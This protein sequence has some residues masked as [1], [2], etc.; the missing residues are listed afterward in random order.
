MKRAEDGPVPPKCRLTCIGTHGVVSHKVEP[1]KFSY[2][3]RKLFF[4]SITKKRVLNV[5]EIFCVGQLNIIS[6][7]HVQLGTTNV[8]HPAWRRARIPPP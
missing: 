5:Q 8:M 2:I 4:C 6:R 3:N 7:S 1:S